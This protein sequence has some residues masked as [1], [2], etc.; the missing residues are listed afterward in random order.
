MHTLFHLALLQSLYIFLTSFPSYQWFH[1]N[2]TLCLNT[3]LQLIQR[4]FTL[5]PLILGHHGAMCCV[6]MSNLTDDLCLWANQLCTSRMAAAETMCLTRLFRGCYL[7]DI[8]QQFAVA[9]GCA[10]HKLS[11]LSKD[12]KAETEIV[13]SPSLSAVVFVLQIPNIRLK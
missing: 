6:P 10:Q 13:E 5:S 9:L 1:E 7:L 2:H 3:Y 12:C 11:Q 4:N 8:I